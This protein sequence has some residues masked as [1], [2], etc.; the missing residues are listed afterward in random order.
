MF[1]FFFRTKDD[2]NKQNSLSVKDTGEQRLDNFI[3]FAKSTTEKRKQ[4]FDELISFALESNQWTNQELR[5]KN[6]KEDRALVFN[7][8]NEYVKRYMARL[9]PRNAQTGIMDLGVKVHEVNHDLKKKF[10]KEIFDV[11]RKYDI[12]NTILEQGLNFLTGGAAVLYYPQD[13]ITK[14]AKLFSLDP[15]NCFL[16]WSAGELVQF[17]YQEYIGDGKYNVTYWDLAVQIIKDGYTGKVQTFKND[18]Q[19]IPIS[20]IPNFPRPHSHEGNPETDLLYELDKEYNNQASNYSKRVA[21]NTEPHLVILSDT[22]DAKNVERGKNK[23]T[24]LG[25]SDDM[26]YLELK[27]GVEIMNWLTKIEQR[28]TNKTGIVNTTSDIKTNVSGKSLSFQYSDMMD[29]IGFMRIFWDKGIRGMNRAI[30]TYAYG[31]ADYQ[32]DPVYQPFLQQDASERITQY[33]DMLDADLIT[34]LDAIDELRGVENAEE[35][36][37]E[38]LKEKE[39]FNKINNKSNGQEPNKPVQKAFSPGQ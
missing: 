13:A 26:K 6:A 10:E 36:L 18:L 1:N 11:Y 5:E 32:T 35:K 9:F 27:E 7:F 2:L 39:L 16:G 22:V 34:H 23:K 20:W 28:I 15:R 12:T 37:D 25:S 38:I 29:L 19:I 31:P 17:A 30:L 3:R 14:R 33:V 24:R 4:L 21:E 8:S